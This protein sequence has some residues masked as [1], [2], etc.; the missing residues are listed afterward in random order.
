MEITTKKYNSIVA[1]GRDLFWKHGFKRVTVDEVCRKADVSKMTFYKYFPDKTELAM[2][3]F[4]MIVAEGEVMFRKIMAEDSPAPEKIKKMIMMKLESTDKISSEF[5]QDFY[6]GSS[7]LSRY[8]EE[9]TR[10]AWNLLIDDIKKAQDEGIFR[11]DFRPELIMKIQSK[12][13]EL[14]EDES[15]VSL[16]KS[17]QELIYEFAKF[18][19][20][21]IAPHE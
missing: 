10:K 6:S 21:G 2:K 9:R 17:R 5:L 8:V 3:V 12:I 13:S 7:E 15:V 19:F 18:M 14:L 1:A 4:D 20:Y 16:Y 11:Q